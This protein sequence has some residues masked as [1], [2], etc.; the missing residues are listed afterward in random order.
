MLESLEDRQLLS[1][2]GV[3]SSITDLHGQTTVYAIGQD[4]QIYESS[5]G[6]WQ[7]LS[8]NTYGFK[9]VSAGLDSAGNAH[10]FAVTTSGALYELGG[11]GLWRVQA[12]LTTGILH[13]S[14]TTNNECYTIWASDHSVSR[15]SGRWWYALQTPNSDNVQISAGV[16][17]WGQDK[18]YCLTSANYVVEVN[19]NGSSDWLWDRSTGWWLR[20]T[21]LSAGIGSN[22]TGTDLFYTQLGTNNAYYFN[23][24]SSRYLMASAIQI[25]AGLDQWGDA[26]LLEIYSGDHALYRSDIN[27][28][29]QYE[30]GQW[31]Q[32]SAAQGDMVFAIEAGSQHVFA[33]DP[34]NNWAGLWSSYWPYQGGVWGYGPNWHWWYGVSAN[35]F[36][37]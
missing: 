28:N 30:G 17:Q 2:A 29:W 18:V 37:S 20:A 24:T 4:T 23:G 1:T 25:S 16:D 6:T 26:T 21:Q 31:T 36:S 14:A 12:Q 13:V 8:S 33:F 27:G 5:N 19:N 32:I 34:N 3:I 9:E 22:S 11:W 15:Y 7:N 10:C 35:P